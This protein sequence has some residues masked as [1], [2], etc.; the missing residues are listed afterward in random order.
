MREGDEKCYIIKLQAL[1]RKAAMILEALTCAQ[2]TS[3]S[4]K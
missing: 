1:I 3:K 2:S 4:E